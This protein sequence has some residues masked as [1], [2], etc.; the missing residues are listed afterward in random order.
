MSCR[1]DPYNMLRPVCFEVSVVVA[2]CGKKLKPMAVLTATRQLKN[3]A[4]SGTPVFA[5]QFW[6][7][8]ETGTLE[9]CEQEHTR[10]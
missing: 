8:G 10:A 4:S 9:G 5:D 2:G 6:N 1:S 7:D 3:C